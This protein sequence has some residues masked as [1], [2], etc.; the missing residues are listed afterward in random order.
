MPASPCRITPTFKRADGRIRQVRMAT[1]AE[2]EAFAI[3]P[4]LNLSPAPGGI[5]KTIV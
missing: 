2:P 4:A 3:Y 5:V 1:R